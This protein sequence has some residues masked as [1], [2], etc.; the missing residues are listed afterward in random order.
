M[1]LSV[2]KDKRKLFPFLWFF[3]PA[4]AGFL[5]WRLGEVNNYNIFTGVYH[6][7]IEGLNLYDL[8]PKEYFD[9]N[10]YGPLFSLIIMPFTYIPNGIGIPLWNCLQAFALYKALT[11][12]PIK[13]AYQWILLA[14]C[15]VDLNTSSHSVQ[16]NPTVVAFII[17]SWHFVKKDQVIWATLFVMLGAFVKL[18]GIVGL[19]FWVFSE[20]KIKYIAYCFLWAIVLFVLPMAISSPSFIVQSYLD[21]YNSLVH[22][23]I[24]NQGVENGMG[25]SMQDVS[26][27]G[28]V[29]RVGG[30]PQLSNLFFIIPGFI[31]QV[32]PLL[33]FKQ[34][35]NIL[36]QLRYL[37]SLSI[38]VVIFS[39]SSESPTF[40]IAVT[41]V[42]IWF[43]T[44]DFPIQ[45]W[46]WVLLI[47]VT[48]VTS[49]TATDI[50]PDWLRMK[51]ILYSIKAFPCCLVWFACIY[52]LLFDETSEI[53]TLWINQ[54]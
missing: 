27:M 41:G 8:Y 4:L 2:F 50:F 19:A 52:Q 49:L 32:M 33:R 1:I 21:W 16:V 35:K 10:H 29:R 31:L 20:S 51:I 48:V 38:F 53:K 3:T 6:H 5:K 42:A 46:V 24:Q 18:Y 47:T 30:F 28:L 44:Q 13:P 45:K 7:L 43:I 17:F 25:T 40:I 15:L 11:L 12:L 22:K 23:N 54:D 37:A 39:S 36:F 26:L 14:I 34:Y 9:S